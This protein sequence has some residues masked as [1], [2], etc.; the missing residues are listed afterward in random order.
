MTSDNT[1][2]LVFVS[3]LADSQKR[4]SALLW[5]ASPASGTGLAH[6]LV[7]PELAEL[8]R[9]IT[10]LWP[11]TETALW[12]ADA[13]EALKKS[14]IASVPQAQLHHSD[15]QFTLAP[16]AKWC[17]GKWYLQAPAQ[18]SKAQSAS[19]SQTLQL[20]QL[21][22]SDADTRDLEDVFRR[23][24]TLSY[25]LLR[26]VNSPAMRRS[27]EITSFGQAILLLGRQQ[28]KR[29][30]NLLM[31]SARD[32]DERSGLLLAHVCLR[33]RGMELLAQATGLDRSTQEQAFMIGMFSLLGVLFGSPLPD[34]LPPLQLSEDM[35]A[36]LLHGQGE[37]G[38]LLRDWQTIE[39]ADDPGLRAALSAR[40]INAHDYNALLAQACQWMLGLT[41]GGVA[42]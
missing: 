37:L 40:G 7:S 15:T 32:D 31:F 42:S 11:D 22:N 27:R 33:A 28:L 21:V 41:R 38:A 29:W 25:Q 16:G 34:L 26:L 3:L 30:I 14:G 24:A 23:D 18:P 4:L 5:S 19:R 10:C 17:A 9:E 39:T 13:Q 36:A 12:P 20:L 2:S 1:P 35:N 6:W 8:S